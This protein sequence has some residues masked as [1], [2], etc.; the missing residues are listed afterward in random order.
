MKGVIIINQ[1]LGMSKGKIA[2]VCAHLGF[3]SN[4]LLKWKGNNTWE[5]EGMK[6]VV[7]KTMDYKEILYY[8]VKNFIKYECHIDAGRTQ[9]EPLSNC[10]V[11]FFCKEGEYRVIEELK[12]L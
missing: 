3:L 2:R 9:V 7:L 8:I 11:V 6:L 4:E 10:G 5:Q 1:S 12:L